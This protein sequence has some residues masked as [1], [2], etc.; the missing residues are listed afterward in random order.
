MCDMRKPGVCICKSK[1]EDQL[2]SDSTADQHLSFRYIDCAIPL[3]SKS[4]ISSCG[5]TAWFVTDLV[6]N[7]KDKFSHDAAHKMFTVYL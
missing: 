7:H 4:Q 3:I 1:G 2:R 6:G 5:C